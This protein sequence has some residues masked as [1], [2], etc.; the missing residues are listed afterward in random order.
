MSEPESQRNEGPSSPLTLA[1]H[2]NHICS[3]FEALYRAGQ[4]PQIED[5]LG[6]EPEPARSALLRELLELELDYRNRNGETP[7]RNT[8][9]L[10]FPS[11]QR[12]IEAVFDSVTA[13]ERADRWK[14]FSQDCTGRHRPEGNEEAAPHLLAPGTN[15]GECRIERL[16]GRGGMGEVYLA[17][18]QV[19]GRQVAVKVL[20]VSRAA[21]PT[22]TQRFL[23]EVKAL[24][25]MGSHPG[26]VTAFH[27]SEEDGR[28]YL[29]MEYVPGVDMAQ[30][31]KEH[32]SLRVAQACDFIRQAAS[33]L[34]YAHQRGIVHRDIKPSN[35]LVTPEGTIKILDLGLARLA[36]PDAPSTDGSQTHPGALL[37]TPD[38]VAPEQARDST[39][40][41]ARSDLY[42]LGCTFYYLLTGQPPFG[43]RS[44]LDKLV[45]HATETPLPLEQVRPGLPG[46]ITQIV[47]KL[48]AKDPED[49]FPSA[50]AL[51]DA[52]DSAAVSL[53][54]TS[55]HTAHTPAL[56]WAKRISKKWRLSLAILLLA[57]LPIATAWSLLRAPKAGQVEQHPLQET[58]VSVHE[59]ESSLPAVN[60]AVRNGIASG[61]AA[62]LPI[63]D[64]LSLSIRRNDDDRQITTYN[65]VL[66]G[67]EQNAEVIDPLGPKD[68]FKIKGRFR[69]PTNCYLLWFDTRGVLTVELASQGMQTRVEYP[70][71][72][73]SYIRVSQADPP[74]Q[75]LLLLAAGSL[76]P[77]TG[78]NLLQAQLGKVGKP[79]S[80]HGPWSRLHRGPGE[81]VVS[82]PQLSNYRKT[83][84]N[85]LPSGVAPLHELLLRAGK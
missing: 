26:I 55:G 10:R 71:K 85:L 79:P 43:S 46:T 13:A 40:A 19:L 76:A 80:E 12:L 16:L 42:S 67:V 24:A 49:R 75:H 1:R 47:Q 6:H 58:G 30:Y 64:H 78:R 82:Q 32:G 72:E 25:R 4:K 8:Y 35:L 50:G 84:Q 59:A 81:T 52:L 53:G 17:T 38:Y 37:G 44:H 28:L 39:R 15:L 21:D 61:A 34:D 18:H 23:K 73:D 57:V 69:E 56:T 11:D 36:I 29:V 51:L 27:A 77:E 54:A 83:I 20:P 48:L 9:L 5:Y 70:D 3:E 65:L 22:A 66:N 45:A 14:T 60:P 41:D 74:G 2:I 68:A 31:V 63:L 33:A 62:M 7:D